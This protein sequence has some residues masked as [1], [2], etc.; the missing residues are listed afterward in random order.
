MSADIGADIATYLQAQGLGVWKNVVPANNTIFLDEL[1]D[2]PADCVGIWINNGKRPEH[3]CGADLGVL[4]Y[5]IADIIVRN[6]SKAT[7]RDRAETIR[8]LFSLSANLG[9]EYVAEMAAGS[10]PVYLGR[11]DSNRHK[12]SVS[13]ELTVER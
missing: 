9:N 4:E 6:A 3:F 1:P 12:F 10:Y 13:I 8:Q 5:P 11:D 7:A 2:L